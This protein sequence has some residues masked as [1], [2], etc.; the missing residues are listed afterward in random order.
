MHMD[1]CRH[2]FT[3]VSYS[4]MTCILCFFI[5]ELS[6]IVDCLRMKIHNKYFIILCLIFYLRMSFDSISNCSLSTYLTWMIISTKLGCVLQELKGN[7]VKILL[8]Q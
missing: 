1:F 3:L 8:D 2:A 7:T 4:E 6:T 5:F